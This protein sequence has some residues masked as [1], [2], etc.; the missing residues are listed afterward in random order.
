MKKLSNAERYEPPSPEFAKQ[1]GPEVYER[2]RRSK[3]LY[4]LQSEIVDAA[5]AWF[6]DSDQGTPIALEQKLKQTIKDMIDFRE[7]IDY[8][9]IRL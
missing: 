4:Y 8:E 2:F 9:S 6:R 7:E 5:I 3:R 1:V